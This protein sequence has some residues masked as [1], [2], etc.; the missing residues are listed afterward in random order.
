MLQ[1]IFFSYWL[2]SIRIPVNIRYV[3][4]QIPFIGKPFTSLMPQLP[5]LFKNIRYYPPQKVAQPLM[6]AEEKKI[7]K[8]LLGVLK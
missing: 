7:C 4:L 2:A 8:R 5:V 6:K 3:L 1:R